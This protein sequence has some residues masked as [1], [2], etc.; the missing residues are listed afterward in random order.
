MAA[1]LGSHIVLGYGPAGTQQAGDALVL[2]Y[3]LPAST[4]RVAGARHV[5]WG[6]A[7]LVR[8]TARV[9]HGAATDRRPATRA[10]WRS[11][12]GLHAAQRSPWG[13]SARTDDARH[14]PWGGPL[15]RLQPGHPSPWGLSRETDDA[16]RAPW[17]GPLVVLQ[18]ESL[19]PWGLSIKADDAALLPWGGPLA[20]LQ[21]GHPAPWGRAR[22]ADALR[23]APWTRY[24]QQLRYTL[25]VVPPVDPGEPPAALLYILPARFYMTVHSVVAERLPDGAEI[26]IYQA[27]V[28]ADAGSFAW[29]F[30][31]SGPDS[32]FA[33]L[34][35]V[36][37]LPARLRLTIDGIQFV[38]L[39]ESRRRMVQFG[40]HGVSVSGRSATAL[41][42][43]PWQREATHSAAVAR[44][45]QQL[46]EDALDL[47]GVALDWGITDWLVPGG[48]WSHRGTPLAAVMAIAQAAGARVLSHRSAP[49]LRV[50]HPYPTAPWT[51]SAGAADV[52]LAPDALITEATE[53]GGASD[54]NAVYVSGI[55]AGVLGRVLRAGT[56]GDKLA[57][58]VTDAL[59]T[60]VDAARQRG[61]AILGAAGVKQ[62]VT[63][64]LPVLTGAGSDPG[65]LDVDQLVQINTATPWRA[66]VR[67][68][69]VQAA[70]PGVR[71]QVRLECHIEE[72]P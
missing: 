2:D 19:V 63:L 15:A 39:V 66:R 9:P 7:A 36:D 24:S 32:L 44:T 65:I 35:P 64:D 13:L 40:R 23:H 12:A 38:F 30:T 5:P 31:A 26:P 67:A 59:I 11:G 3:S 47:T 69:S 50:R 46:A 17:G 48:A 49:T 22:R 57:P 61:L 10:P 6:G 52:E 41:L 70:M 20:A 51:W 4:R 55:T 43:A 29:S 58:M 33:Q 27:S 62:D 14:V 37:G 21:P 8:Q 25:V 71:Q 16:L 72:A 28:S 68:V 54:I 53:Q 34:A 42:G 60:H 18:P 1:Q 56:A 45:A